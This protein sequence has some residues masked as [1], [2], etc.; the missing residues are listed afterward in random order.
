MNLKVQRIRRVLD[1][2]RDFSSNDAIG[3]CLRAE[4][5]VDLLN[6][7]GHGIGIDRL[8]QADLARLVFNR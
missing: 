7:P 5:Q 1:V 8:V 4:Y 6:Q 2:V 3:K